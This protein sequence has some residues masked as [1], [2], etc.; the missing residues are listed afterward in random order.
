MP[1]Q[2]LGIELVN[3]F[4]GHLDADAVDHQRDA[5]EQGDADDVEAVDLGQRLELIPVQAAPE[6]RH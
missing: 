1:S 4:D 5:A 3:I 2:H 6:L